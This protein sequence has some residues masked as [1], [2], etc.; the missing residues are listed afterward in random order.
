MAALHRK[1]A[2]ISMARRPVAPTWKLQRRALLAAS[3]SVIRAEE[4]HKGTGFLRVHGAPEDPLGIDDAYEA[5]LVLLP[6]SE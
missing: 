3:C 5:A 2:S 1:Q 4:K 6:P